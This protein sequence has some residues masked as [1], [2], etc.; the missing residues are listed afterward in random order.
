M[1]I[2]DTGR[3]FPWEKAYPSSVNWR[4][5]LP[6]EPITALFDKSVS[7]Y[8]DR[9]CLE[10]LGRTLSYRAVGQAVNRLAKGLQNKGFKKGDKIGLF[11]PNCPAYV[12]AY[13]AILKIG[14]TVVNFNP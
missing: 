10:F 2:L 9:P 11:L 12:I 13:F 1:K 7:R 8:G 4:A 6:V 3:I 14:G 5:P